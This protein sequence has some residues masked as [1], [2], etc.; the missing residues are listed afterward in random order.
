M[1]ASISY[2]ENIIW[3]N[4]L[5]LYCQ[6]KRKRS[7]IQVTF[8]DFPD[9]IV[10]GDDVYALTKENNTSGF[11]NFTSGGYHFVSSAGTSNVGTC[12]E[13]EKKALLKLKENLTDSSG[14]LSSWIDQENCCQWHG[15]TCDNKTGSV[16][17]LDLRNQLSRNNG[18]GGEI[19]PS[20]LELKKLRYLDLSMNNFGGVKVP[21]FIGRVKELRYLNLSGAS[22]SGSVS[23]FLGNLSNLQVLDLSFY[24]EKPPENDLEWLRG[25]S[26]LEHL[27][28]GGSD[29]SKVADSWLHT[30][31]NHSRSLLELRLPQCQLLKLPSSFPSLRLSSLLVLDLSNNAFN[32]STFP[33]WM[34]ELSNLVHLDL[35]SNNI[36]TEL[37]DEFA[38]LSSLEYLDVS[39]NYGIKGPLKKSLGR[40]CNLKTLI[41]SYNSISGD[42]TDF[43]DA[44]SEC[45]SNSLEALDLNFNELSGNLPA[46]LGQLKK[47]KILQLRF[48]SLTGTIPESIGGLSSLE[49]FYLTSNKMSGNLTPNIGQLTS[50]VSL[51]ISD[52][53]WEGIVTETHLLNLSNLQEFSVGMTLGKNITLTFNI[54]RN[55]TP[56][57]KLTFLT[58]QSCQ[59]GPEFPHWLKDQNE[60]TSLIFNTAGISD[61]VPDWFEDLDLK[62][63]N[64][65]MAYNNLSG[66]VPDK[67]QFNFLAN[68]DL[69]SNR[70]EVPLPLWSSNI[71]SLYLRDN[72]FSGPIPVNICEALP[73]LTDL[74]IS[75]N[76]LNGAI[77][78]CMGDMNQLTTLALDNNQLIGQIPDFWGKLPYLYLLD[79]SENRLSGQIPGSLGS[80]AYLRFLRLS[81]NNLSGEM[82][83]SLRNCMRMISI[84]L[85]N[86]QLSGLIP[87][88]L[89][90][91]MRSLLILSVRN[92]RFSGPIPLKVCSLSGLHILDLSENNL[93]GS[94]PS[95]V[96]NLEGFKDELTSAEA[97][98]YQGKLK[99]EAKGRILYYDTI[100]YL[101]NSIDL[102]SNSLSGEIPVEITSLS[103]LGTLNLSGNH[104]T[105]TIPT[106][107]G[108]L[109]WIETLDLSKNQ[110]S[111]PIP[112][113]L[114]TLDFLTH[115]NLSYNNL[116]GRIPTSTEFQTKDDP[117]IFQGND[118]LCG[119]PLQQCSNGGTTISDGGMDD[120]GETDDED[121]LEKIW[122]FAFAGLGYLVGFWVFFGTLIFK[123]SWR[124][125]YFRL[126]ETCILEFH[127]WFWSFLQKWLGCLMSKRKKH[128]R[129][130]R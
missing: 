52:N 79:M 40:L 22:F 61:A 85:S 24:S 96:G 44:L 114:T 93:S 75:H 53:M 117:T 84:D 121:K 124:I 30:I 51:D 87:S 109:G 94:I 28:L 129:R 112:P 14:R 119:P 12:I 57:F 59:L 63:D 73:N 86:N 35:N 100:L 3:L 15:V 116:S 91:T 17:K 11:G 36:V 70:F 19:N 77:P 8:G 9:K 31:N 67:F 74:D 120:D 106:D 90:E 128:L 72:L 23:S 76:N 25:L 125:A 2:K 46:T 42:I 78:L 95:C 45:Q 110:L 115:L 54:S 97:S 80:L 10:D 102:S 56:S 122:F 26:F 82:P 58:I 126:I 18:L 62:L 38:K 88:W 49:T 55:W 103:K 130:R 48:N 81:G 127:E 123:K 104:L 29:L 1:E 33:E 50:L 6:Q 43:V 98:Q 83:S 66:N 34:F 60:L 89:G 64:L 39:S 105:G 69:S 111:G 107:I 108:N 113:S 4:T 68:V 118:A 41:L 7:S 71:T 99:L 27:N 21:E 13:N 65:D 92:N 37:P 101:V 20:L 32:S 47:L 5:G 16:V